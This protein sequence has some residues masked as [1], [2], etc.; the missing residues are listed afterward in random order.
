MLTI[1]TPDDAGKI[2]AF[3]PECQV[4]EPLRDREETAVHA[5]DRLHEA[6]NLRGET[7]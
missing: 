3:R 1:T 5:R 7:Q 4:D 2:C 6:H